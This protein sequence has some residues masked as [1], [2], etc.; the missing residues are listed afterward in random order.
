MSSLLVRVRGRW[1]RRRPGPVIRSGDPAAGLRV[2]LSFDDGPSPWTA[3][4]LDA[5]REHGASATFFVM[6]KAIDGHEDVLRRICAEGHELGNHLHSHSDA[7]ELGDRRIAAELRATAGRIEQLGLRAPVLVRPP[8]GADPAR[9]AR[10]ARRLGMG[11]AVL[12]TIV[13]QDWRSEASAIVEAVLAGLH[14]GAIVDLHDGK[15]HATSGSPTRAATVAAVGTLLG[16]LAARG[17]RCVTV[18]EL[19]R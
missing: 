19:L 11:P 13:P 9:V 17:Y 2:A 3:P 14:P 8:Y 18:S 6:G 16:E 7:R 1:R 5:L 10:I 12:W 15:S 4:I